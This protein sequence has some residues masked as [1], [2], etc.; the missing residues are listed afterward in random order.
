MEVMQHL[1][2]CH[3]CET[4]ALGE[5][6]P[7]RRRTPTLSRV[8]IILSVIVFAAASAV[9]VTQVRQK[10]AANLF[11]RLA[12]A[13]QAPTRRYEGRISGG[14]AWTPSR[15]VTRSNSD[16]AASA[17]SRVLAGTILSNFRG[18]NPSSDDHAAA[19]AYL[20]NQNPRQAIEILEPSAEQKHDAAVWNDLAAAY[21]ARAQ[22]A[23]LPELLA[24]AVAAA[25]AAIDIDKNY[26]E[27]LFNR[28]VALERL[29]L[30]DA[31]REAWKNYLR[32]AVNDGWSR[33]AKEHLAALS[34]PLAN[35]DESFAHDSGR[36]ASGDTT[37][38]ARLV[39]MF[40]DQSRAYVEEIGLTAWA[41]SVQ[42]DPDAA[43]R[44]L[45]IAR[46]I[47][48][49]L[50]TRGDTLVRDQVIAIDRLHGEELPAFASAQAS[51]GEGRRLVK[52]QPTAAAPLLQEAMERFNVPH[53]P[54]VL[55][56][57]LQIAIALYQENRIDDARQALEQLL[58]EI[59]QAD[60]TLRAEA[61]WQ[62][63]LCASAESQW[64]ITIRALDESIAIFES[65]G[66]NRSAAI[67]RNMLAEL[68][69]EIG[70]S[71]KAWPLKIAV[72][73]DLG[74]TTDIRTET[75]ISAISHDAASHHHWRVALSF[76]NL[77]VGMAS[78][79][80]NPD[81][82]ADALLR[83]A[84]AHSA[85]GQSGEAVRDLTEAGVVIAAMKDPALQTRSRADLLA[86]NAIVA[87]TPREAI[88]ALTTAIDFHRQNG[89]R[90]YLPT[91]YLRRGRALRAAGDEIRARRDFEAG[92]AELEQSRKSLPDIATRLGIFDASEDLFVEAISSALGRGDT[93]SAFSYAEEA[94]ARALL[95]TM[96]NHAAPST[97][98]DSVT[99]VE[100]VDLRSRLVIFAID[101]NGIHVAEGG[102][103]PDRIAAQVTR[104]RKAA[105]DGQVG[106]ADILSNSLYASTIGPVAS[107]LPN[108][109][110]VVF[111]PSRS[112]LSLPFA[113]LRNEKGRYFIE[114][115]PVAVA[116]SAAVF[117]R[118]S[119]T[120][121][122]AAP[123]RALLVAASSADGRE[124]LT[125]AAGEIRAIARTYV[126]PISLI[127]ADATPSAFLKAASNADVIQVSSHGDAADNGA[128][129]TALILSGKAGQLTPKQV[130]RLN[131]THTSVVVLAACDTAR[132]ETR[133]TEGSLSMA[134]AFLAAGVPSV[135]ATLWQIP[136]SGAAGFFPT[137]HRYLSAGATPA[138]AV[139][140]A[141]ID[142][143]HRSSVPLSTWASV[144]VIGR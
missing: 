49:E 2:A 87:S 82:H 78:Q 140:N 16:H 68:Y 136:D 65:V 74:R 120:K 75:A 91:F 99:V 29:G 42:K 131:L 5:R 44:Y 21:I 81:A 54:M 69:D 33:E 96:G 102:T 43:S 1:V 36:I 113:A 109:S 24:D 108:Q 95:D 10:T 9:I 137:L 12:A 70:D 60:Q 101:H 97:L 135:V 89:R 83:R 121:P 31:A 66:E 6:P 143:I 114:D 142:S 34:I 139:R 133:W 57:R 27:A 110:K 111:V 46:A 53:A 61:L 40:P 118:A 112:L 20:V 8:Q 86:V 127:G 100:Y 32:H 90:M 38:A 48:N 117:M 18:N 92:I 106:E 80:P 4:V 123:E 58:P 25:D 125:E 129:S 138:E 76:L 128:R 14:F 115:H 30:R 141:Q 105:A 103:T 104:F 94:R 93:A 132:G 116:P 13:T 59:P 15:Y 126:H 63:G 7:A 119:S 85:L 71:A 51:L 130:E 19:A 79:F 41:T 88:S 35:F 122:T 56:V 84:V 22:Q 50:A 134:R 52:T 72:L 73:R 37:A 11:W 124:E 67:V 45:T 39:R 28:A 98:P 107:W 144:Q 3:T 47:G 62:L 17:S 23:D 64:G 77:E 55:Y 26:P